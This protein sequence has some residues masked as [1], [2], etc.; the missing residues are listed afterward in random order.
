MADSLGCGK[1]RTDDEC[2]LFSDGF[3]HS[4]V[5]RDSLEDASNFPAS[6]S[7]QACRAEGRYAKNISTV[8][9]RHHIGHSTL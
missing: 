7:D 4:C 9:F 2:A 3:G 8:F 1:V 6:T 5:N